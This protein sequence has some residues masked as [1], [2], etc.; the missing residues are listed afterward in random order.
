MRKSIVFPLVMVLLL[1]LRGERGQCFAQ[2]SPARLKW[3]RA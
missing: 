2:C 1:R 3:K